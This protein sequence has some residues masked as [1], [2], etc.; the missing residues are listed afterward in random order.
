[1]SNISKLV[2]EMLAAHSR[3]IAAIHNEALGEYR[4]ERRAEFQRAQAALFRQ[5]SDLKEDRD[6][7][8]EANTIMA[9]NAVH[10]EWWQTPATN[11]LHMKV[12]VAQQVFHL[13]RS[14]GDVI[15]YHLVN[16]HKSL[17]ERFD[18]STKSR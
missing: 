2:D 9:Q 11:L 7:L 15:Q 6:K 10:G 3:Y 17:L 14:P 12:S 18:P 8:L 16:M 4:D 1:M 5:F 13:A